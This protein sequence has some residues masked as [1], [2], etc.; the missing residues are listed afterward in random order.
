L[1]AAR[2]LLHEVW[3][4]AHGPPAIETLAP[5]IRFPV[6]LPL[7]EH[8][9]ELRG[10]EGALLVPGYDDMPYRIATVVKDPCGI[11]FFRGLNFVTAHDDYR[12]ALLAADL[13]YF[14]G[15]LF[16]GD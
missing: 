14:A 9:S 1:S 6:Y 2:D 4:L 11:R 8:G 3:H 7:R 15:D 16:V 5:D 13:E 12:T 10:R